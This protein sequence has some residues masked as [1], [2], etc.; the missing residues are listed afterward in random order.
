[1]LESIVLTDD[2]WT[3]ETGFLTAA[4]STFIPDCRVHSLMM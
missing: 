4:Q 3:P 1:M 2:E